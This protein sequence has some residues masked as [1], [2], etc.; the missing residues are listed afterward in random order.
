[1]KVH[2]LDNLNS[3]LCVS[4]KKSVYITI[5]SI[6]QIVERL[7][8]LKIS[9]KYSE[10]KMKKVSKKNENAKPEHCYF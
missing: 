6:V 3:T 5:S 9:K 7:Y 10:K 4:K 1:M 2:L 8:K